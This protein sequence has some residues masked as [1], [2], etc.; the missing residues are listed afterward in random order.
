M[1]APILL[2]GCLL[3]SAASLLG[4]TTASQR[5]MVINVPIAFRVGDQ[6]LP[7]GQYHIF[8]VTP[9]RSIRITH[10]KGK[11]AAIVLTMP[12]YAS[13]PSENDRL[14]FRRYADKYFLTEVW[15]AGQNV[16]RNPMLSKKAIE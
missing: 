13:A 5:L 14:V 2:I 11:P 16:A 1:K 15:T 8:T 6:S 3:F 12:Q 9:E 7:P 10:A 4:Q